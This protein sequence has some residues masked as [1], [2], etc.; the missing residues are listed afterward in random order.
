MVEGGRTPFL[1]AGRLESLGYRL[2][3]FPN[4]LTRVFARTG[5]ELM[6]ELRRSGTTEAFAGRMYDH[7]ALWSLFDYDTWLALEG[8]YGTRG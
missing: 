6:N 1:P 8:R 3:I 4:S 5:L 2:A 7:R